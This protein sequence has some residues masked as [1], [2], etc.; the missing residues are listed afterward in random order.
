MPTAS[1]QGPPNNGKLLQAV[2]SRARLRCESAAPARETHVAVFL[3]ITREDDES[4]VT[5]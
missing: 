1:K 4:G 2:Q 5:R 3:W